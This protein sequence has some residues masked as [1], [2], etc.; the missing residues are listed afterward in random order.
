MS[1]PVMPALPL[2]MAKGLH[3]TPNFEWH[4]AAI[5]SA[6]GRGNRSL[7]VKPYSTWGFEFDLD[8]I[9]VSHRTAHQRVPGSYNPLFLKDLARN[10]P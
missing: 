3:K 8:K 10:R 4:N 2:S 7:V 9:Q 5:K 1:Y 6:A